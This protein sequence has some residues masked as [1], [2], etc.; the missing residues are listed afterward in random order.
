M[1]DAPGLELIAH[2]V[3]SEHAGA[4]TGTSFEH[5]QATL[6]ADPDRIREL[7]TTPPG[8]SPGTPA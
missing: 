8:G 1:P 4:V 7:L 3:N 5:G 6:L 2:E